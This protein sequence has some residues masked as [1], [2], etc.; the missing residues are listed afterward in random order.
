MKNDNLA[1]HLSQ[2][3]HLNKEMLKIIIE[4]IPANVFFKDTDCKY[5]MVS[6]VC[7][8]LNGGNEG[9]TIIGKTDFEVQHDPELA[10]F[11]YEDDRKI[12]ETRKGNR[13]ISE[14]V[15]NGEKYYY[16]IIKEPVIDVEGNLIGIIGLV[17]DITALK[18]LQEELRVIS[19]TD[20]LTGVYNRTYFEQKMVELMSNG[21]FTLSIIMC[22]S[23]GLK[24]FNDNFGHKK[25]DA[26]LIETVCLIKEVIGD[27]GEVM[28][29]GGDEFIIFCL[30]CSEETCKIMVDE[31]RSKEKENHG[32]GLPISSSYGYTTVKGNNTDLESAIKIA[33]EMMYKEKAR[34]K[35]DYIKKLK[36]LCATK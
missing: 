1:E 25:G 19:I 9:W 10:K 33:E 30:D 7:H 22:D 28:R 16:D 14:M 8:M 20:K 2:K 13:Y 5:Q 31:L 29:I 11:Y 15:F 17:N 26:L 34:V 3:Y 12:I 21:F 23:N 4:A 36:E 6:H 35:A 27:A 18:R 24:F 32:I